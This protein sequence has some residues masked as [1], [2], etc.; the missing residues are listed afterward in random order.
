MKTPRVSAVNRPNR[1][2]DFIDAV[3][4][5]AEHAFPLA[6]AAEGE[7]LRIVAMKSGKGFVRKIGDLGLSVG[8]GIT[9]YQRRAGGS[10]VVG[11]DT[12]R[13][14]LGAAAAQRIMVTLQAMHSEGDL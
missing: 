4:K 13:I 7:S 12:L 6:L 14:A 3:R 8:S 5:G 10:M 9:V 2:R 11:R 1:Q